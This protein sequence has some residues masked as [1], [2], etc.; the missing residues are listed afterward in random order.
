MYS[1][2]LP[3]LLGGVETPA[4]VVWGR[5]DRVVPVECGERFRDLLPRARLELLDDCGHFVDL[6]QPREL[7]ALVSAFIDQ[8]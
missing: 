2:T 6:E 5:Q 8:Q 1:Q 4:L 3:H 7:S